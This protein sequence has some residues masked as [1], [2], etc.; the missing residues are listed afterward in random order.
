MAKKP[1]GPAS[2]KLLVPLS[3]IERRICYIRGA[4]VMIDSDLAELY[5]VPTF[6]L[7]ESV[8]RTC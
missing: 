4:K 1:L 8:K 7:N 5:Q 2:V 6:R 3:L